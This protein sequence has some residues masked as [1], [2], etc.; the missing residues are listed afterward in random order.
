MQEI[1]KINK[2]QILYELRLL[3][4]IGTGFISGK[5][6]LLLIKSEPFVVK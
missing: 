6:F 1:D 2:S 5:K 3:D 4:K